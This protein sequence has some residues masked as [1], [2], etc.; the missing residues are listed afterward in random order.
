MMAMSGGDMG[1]SAIRT[2]ED[3]HELSQLVEDFHDWIVVG[4][5]IGVDDGH[6]ENDPSVERTDSVVTVRFAL[7]C[8]VG[9]VGDFASLEMRF[10]RAF[11]LE[12]FM[13]FDEP[14]TEA[15]LEKTAYGWV[16]CNDGPLSSQ[17]R[18]HPTEIHGWLVVF[19]GGDVFWRSV[20]Q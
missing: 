17:E 14:L 7:D 12:V 5:S 6:N 11:R 18:E 15:T 3:A 2:Q 4:A 20:T 1:W 13:D 10:E 16:L 9:S 19:C 8:P